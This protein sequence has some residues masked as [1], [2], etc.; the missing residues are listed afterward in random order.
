MDELPQGIRE[1]TCLEEGRHTDCHEGLFALQE[2]PRGDAGWKSDT[3]QGWEVLSHRSSEQWR[4]V[5]V[6]YN[7]KTWAIMRRKEFD[8][9]IWVRMRHVETQAELWFGVIHCTQRCSQVAPAQEIHQALETLPPTTLPTVLLGDVNACVGWGKDG[10]G[11]FPFGKDGK[12]LK[13]LDALKSRNLQVHVPREGQRHLPTSKPRK[14]G[15]QGNV[16]DIVASARVETA[17]VIISE[18]S[19]NILGTDHD[20]IFS[21]IFVKSESVR[22]KRY[23]TMPRVVVKPIPQME[24]INEEVLKKVADQCTRGPQGKSYKDT[25]EVKAKFRHARQ[26]RQ[27]VHWKEALNA[28]R[29]AR[30]AWE[31]ERL[32]E[33]AAGNWR[34]IRSTRVKADKW[35]S[36]F[37]EATQGFPHEVIHEHLEKT[38]AGEDMP[39]WEVREEEAIPDF[40]L[41]ELQDAA[42]KSATG[43]AV[44]VDGVSHEL[45]QMICQ[46]EVAAPQLLRWFND[47]LQTGIQ[48]DS[49]CE[50][51]M[52]VLPKIRFPIEAKRV[53]PISLSSATCKLY[54]RMLLERCKDRLGAP[55]GRQCS[56]QGRQPADY[57]YTIHKL[58]HLEREWRMGLRWIKLD[59]SKAFDRVSRGKLMRMIE[60]KVGH[61]RLSKAWYELL[62]PTQSHL[63]TC[64]GSSTFGM[65]AGIRQGSVESPSL[66]GLLA[67]LCVQTTATK[68]GWDTTSPGT[69]G[70]PVRDVLFMDDA[71]AWDV[72]AEDLAARV[73]QLAG[74]LSLWGLEINLSKCQ[75]YCSPYASGDRELVVM[76]TRM[77]SDDH[78]DVMGLCMGVHKT[79]CETLAPLISKAQDGFWAIKHIVCRKQNLRKRMQ[80]MDTVVGGCLLW[81]AGAII[82]DGHALGLMNS[83]QLQ[84]CVWMNNRGR[85]P[86]EDWLRHHIRVRR[87]TR[88]T[89]HRFESTK[90][91]QRVW[92]YSGHRARGVNNDVWVASV[93]ID[94]WG[95]LAWWV[96]EQ[97]RPQGIRHRGRFFARL[98]PHERALDRA[99][100]GPWRE[101]AQ[102]RAMWR[103]REKTFIQQMDVEWASGR[104]DSI[105]WQ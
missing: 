84:F 102:N 20:M 52:I 46:D 101:V 23:N 32:D 25:V 70:L 16:I 81:C 24:F 30:M 73:Q 79:A 15:V 75:Y 29:Q 50:I 59:I 39:A 21:K 48:P 40:T 3:L 82:P 57:I 42:P 67:E 8:R 91:L 86:G 31:K 61:N 26:T 58:F 1:A 104:Q 98:M 95:Q 87:E 103:D 83:L 2:L 94:E 100:G 64:W 88:A 41:Q 51:V 43:K 34:A 10:R 89:M 53:R 80:I 92:R 56:G 27:A 96:R 78:L 13:M 11:L 105:Q 54:S 37:S 85:K 9:G 44:G 60:E 36:G 14:Q 99:A 17:P 71:V 5:G 74:E 63:Q 90:W 69:G 97:D 76:G 68:F 18:D 66:F 19:C 49:W 45:L 12:G 77:R 4:G 72:R 47:I 35:E 93:Q 28:R 55:G 6:M 38:Y 22:R 62:K 33:A 7:P 65:K